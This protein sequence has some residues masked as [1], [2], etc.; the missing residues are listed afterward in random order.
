MCMFNHSAVSLC[1]PMNCSPP[2]SSVHRIFQARILEGVAISHSRASSKPKES[3][4]VSCIFCISMWI[5]YHHTTWE[6]PIL[7]ILL[8]LNVRIAKMHLC[9]I[10]IILTVLKWFWGRPY[11]YS[12]FIDE[13][14]EA[15]KLSNQSKIL[16]V[17]SDGTDSE[18]C[19]QLQN[20]GT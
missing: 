2:G 15:Q 10:F 20:S 5:L 12:L 1:D 13:E 19:S 11:Y 8:V 9:S 4:H 7:I 14:T 16:Q 3:T 18:P 17:L 6:A